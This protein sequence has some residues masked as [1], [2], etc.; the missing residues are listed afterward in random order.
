MKHVMSVLLLFAALIATAD[1]SYIISD[2]SKDEY[3]STPSSGIVL[4]TGSAFPSR[5]SSLEARF[6]TWLESLGTNLK[7]TV[8]KGFFLYLK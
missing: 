6:R 2:H 5:S 3:R 7:T 1:Y 4:D 8:L